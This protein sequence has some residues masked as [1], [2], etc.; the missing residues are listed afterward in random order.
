MLSSYKKNI[1]H[2]L[3]YIQGH[4]AGIEKMVKKD[5]YCINIIWQVLAVIKALKMVNK[6]ILE[7]H[8]KTCVTEA[9]KGKK[10]SER[11][12]KLKELLKLYQDINNR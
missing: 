3:H 9:I 4:I 5:V 6:L 11:K 7:N 8:L 12:K 10:E 1:L 2:R